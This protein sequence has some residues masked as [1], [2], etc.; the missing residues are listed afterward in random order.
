M[1]SKLYRTRQCVRLNLG[2]R[3]IPKKVGAISKTVT[4]NAGNEPTSNNPKSHGSSLK[5]NS[6]HEDETF[7]GTWCS[8]NVSQRS[9]DAHIEK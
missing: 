7:L 1:K 3:Q 9:D 6:D 8:L 5:L 4:V 2:S